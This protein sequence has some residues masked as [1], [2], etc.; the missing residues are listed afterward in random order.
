MEKQEF[1]FRSWIRDRKQNMYDLV[2][3]DD[4]HYCLQT[5]YGTARI[6]FYPDQIVEISIT[7][8]KTNITSFFIVI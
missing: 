4:D 8:A 3:E 1:D 7:S 5:D 2:I 6:N